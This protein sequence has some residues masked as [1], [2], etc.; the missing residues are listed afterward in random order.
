[1]TINETISSDMNSA[2]KTKDELKLST[3]RLVRS[4]LM[5]K[6]IELGH[7]LTDEEAMAVLKS[8]KK[9]FLDALAD[10]E[11]ASRQD[12]I[13][14]QKAELA[15]LE[16]YLPQ[17]MP[18]EELERV[19]TEAVKASSAEGAKDFGKAM[20]AAVKAVEGRAD[21][22]EIRAIVQRLLG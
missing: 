3:L 1:M 17:A 20:G 15:I 18:A 12:L 16:A 11:S 9:Q 22:S 7:E 21:G 2:M 19:V 10:F 14:K 4:S 5:N 6:K 13:E 8:M